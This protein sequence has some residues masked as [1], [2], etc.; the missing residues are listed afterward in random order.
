MLGGRPSSSAAAIAAAEA[1]AAVAAKR[2][3]GRPKKV[4]TAPAAGVAA[5]P[6]GGDSPAAIRRGAIAAASPSRGVL[7]KEIGHST[8]PVTCWSL[9][10]SKRGGDVELILLDVT[11]NFIKT[12][13]IRGGV[14]TEVGSRAHN[15][16]LQ[17]MFE[18]RYPRDPTSAKALTK[19]FKAAVIKP[20]T[21]FQSRCY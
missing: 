10:I 9:T 5:A 6:G 13:C 19:F 1:V 2:G 3:R 18:C 8:F 15:L 11:D 17:G 20:R 4:S 16:H 12:Y 7:Q 21:V 14:S